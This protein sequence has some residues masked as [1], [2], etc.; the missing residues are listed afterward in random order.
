MADSVT[1]TDNNTTAEI[2]PFRIEVP[3]AEL[4]DLRERLER[5]RWPEESPGIGWTRGVPLGYLKDLADYW[6]NGFDWRGQEARLNELPQFTTTIDGQTIHFLH[7]RSPEPGALP[8][9]IC[10]GYPGSGMPC[11]THSWIA[12]ADTVAPSVET[13]TRSTSKKGRSKITSPFFLT[14]RRSLFLETETPKPSTNTSPIILSA[15]SIS[16]TLRRI[17]PKR[18]DTLCPIRVM[19][20]RYSY[21]SSVFCRNETNCRFRSGPPRTCASGPRAATSRTVQNTEGVLPSIMAPS[22]S[23][24]MVALS[25]GIMALP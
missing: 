3:Q 6:A 10:H 4:D 15:G 5:A 21:F 12:A 16:P 25:S 19:W 24:S 14:T 22:S 1:D 18:L 7:V 11:L 17:V 13:I 20:W 9:I 8:L 2:Q 23:G